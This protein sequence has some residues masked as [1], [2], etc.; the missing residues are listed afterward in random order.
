MTKSDRRK[1]F[2]VIL[3]IALLSTAVAMNEEARQLAR[4]ERLSKGD[5]YDRLEAQCRDGCCESSVDRM[6][7][8]RA[9]V[10]PSD[11]CG[12]GETADML[13]CHGSYRWCEPAK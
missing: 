7:Q 1:T 13:R 5:Y 8:A 3:V 12:P 2:L 9:R 4:S 11:G 6:R 10:Q